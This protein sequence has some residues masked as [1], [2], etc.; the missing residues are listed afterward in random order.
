MKYYYN[1]NLE[2][3]R[4]DF[5]G[6]EKY[7]GIF[8]MGGKPVQPDFKEI[9]KWQVG[10]NPQR[11]E[12]R[13]DKFQ[14]QWQE[15]N[16]IF[17]I[18]ENCIVWLGHAGFMIKLDGMTLLTDPV[19]GHLGGFIR[20]KVKIPYESKYMT[21]VDYILMS[22]G[23][24]DHFDVASLKKILKLNPKVEF[25]TALE[26]GQQLIRPLLKHNHFQE[27]AWWQKFNIPNK[28]IEI[29]FLPAQH[30]N[31]RALFDFNKQLWGSFI[32]RTPKIT[33]FFAGDS[34]FM[35]LY[36]DIAKHIGK[37]DIAILPI[38]AYRPS[39]IMQNAHMNPEE[40]FNVFNILN[41]KTFIP[42]HYGT[43]DLSDEP[44]GEP[45]RWLRQLFAEQQHDGLMELGVGEIFY[46]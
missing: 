34:A 28:N 33:I 10:G 24:R 9:L 43:Y 11:K 31:R 41:A 23:H 8:T 6:N 46:F 40:A 18:K 15:N 2:F 44:I 5:Q 13:A 14:L 12:K 19:F 21:N 16:D 42:M 17:K 22:H 30:W 37:I 4:T 27:A 38:G 32:I 3:I 39:I 26:I 20:R 7:E 36:Q 35:D 45:I 1:P 29:I 25:L